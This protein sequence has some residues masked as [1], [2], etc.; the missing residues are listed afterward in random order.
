MI[1]D[2]LTEEEEN[3]K[4]QKNGDTVRNSDQQDAGGLRMNSN[5]TASKVTITKEN[6]SE[7]SK[8]LDEIKNSLEDLKAETF[9]QRIKD[10]IS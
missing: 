5:S 6:A 4:Y 7:Y 10:S 9:L 3:S 1:N 2:I 8:K